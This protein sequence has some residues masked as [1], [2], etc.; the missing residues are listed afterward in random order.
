MPSLRRDFGGMTPAQLHDYTLD[1]GRCSGLIKLLGDFSE[2]FFS[3]TSWWSYSSMIRMM[4]HYDTPLRD[5]AVRARQVSFSSY[6]G[7][8]ESLDDFYIMADGG[9]AT[10]P[11]AKA[12]WQ[13]VA[14]L[15]G[16]KSSGGRSEETSTLGR[17]EPRASTSSSTRGSTGS[18]SGWIS[19]ARSSEP[20]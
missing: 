16:A 12:F 15:G 1:S 18:V 6:P 8:L 14:Y 4:K 7:F 19:A 20:M 2:L 17:A 5:S 11:A 9:A 10:L 13:G 3:H